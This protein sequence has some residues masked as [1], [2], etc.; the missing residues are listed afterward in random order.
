[1]QQI[2]FIHSSVDRHLDRFHFLGMVNNASMN[3]KVYKYLFKSLLSVLLDMYLAVK[4][5]GHMVVL[6]LTF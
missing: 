4:L 6:Y 5:L 2:L 3:I 1:M